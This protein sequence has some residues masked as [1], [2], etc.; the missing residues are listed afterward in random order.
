M[1]GLTPEEEEEL[2]RE[3]ERELA[4]ARALEG[5]G[6]TYWPMGLESRRKKRLEQKRLEE[7][8]ELRAL[9]IERLKGELADRKKKSTRRPRG[10]RFARED[11]NLMVKLLRKEATNTEVERE[12]EI[13]RNRVQKVRE[14]FVFP[15]PEGP[16]YEIE[17]VRG[18]DDV[19]LRKLS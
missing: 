7:E 10:M 15:D 9:E 5:T 11:W 3:H 18:S 14:R 12:T 1:D 8:D 2:R 13:H 4:A 16:V 19:I 17:P 6:T